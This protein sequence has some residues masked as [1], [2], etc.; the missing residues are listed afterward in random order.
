MP[1]TWND[2]VRDLHWE[3]GSSRFDARLGIQAW[4]F[5]QAKLRTSWKPSGR[6]S[7]QRHDLGLAS[8][9]AGL[10]NVIKA[11]QGCDGAILWP[12]IAP[13]M[14]SVTGPSNALQTRDYVVKI[15]GW[16]KTM[17]LER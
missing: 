2:I 9:N 16:W 1:G 11:Q 5:Y 4:A 8:Y 6:T 13:C 3:S 17:E 7:L 10:G 14:V 15:H 12:D